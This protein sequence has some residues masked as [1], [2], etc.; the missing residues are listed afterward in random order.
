MVVGNPPFANQLERLTARD[1]RGSGARGVSAY[2]DL[3]A[4]FLLHALVVGPAGRSA[5]ASCSRS[6]CSRPATP[7]PVRRAV[8][9]AGALTSLW[10]GESGLFDAAVPT[11]ALVVPTARCRAPYAAGGARSFTRLPDR[12]VEAAHLRLE[13]G[14]LLA[15]ALG[16]PEVA[17]VGGRALGEL[18]D[19]TADFRDQY[20]GLEPY[21]H[22]ADPRG[23]RRRRPRHPW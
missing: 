2:T 23:R 9:G 17:L 19:C 1:R 11:C 21:V 12:D 13:W 8:V 18:A 5:R 4:V 20:Y 3:S 14:F 16:V 10:V 6:R 7:P 22:E 15:A